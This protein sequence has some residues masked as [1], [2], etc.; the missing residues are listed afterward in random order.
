MSG[1]RIPNANPFQEGNI[2]SSLFFTAQSE[3]RAD[4]LVEALP[5][6][7][8]G[9]ELEG[10]SNEELRSVV[11]SQDEQE[12]YEDTRYVVIDDQMA[13]GKFG[14]IAT[15]T[16]FNEEPYYT[17]EEFTVE[18]NSTVNLP[19]L[20]P[21]YDNTTL[22]RLYYDDADSMDGYRLVH[23]TETYTLIG[24]LADLS[25]PDSRPQ[26]NSRFTRAH[27]NDSEAVGFRLSQVGNLPDGQMIRAGG[28]SYL[29]DVRGTASVKTFERVEGATITGEAN[30]SEPRNVTAFVRMRT[31]NTER[32][33]PYTKR[34]ETDADGSFEMTVPY[35]TI[36]DV[37]VEE[38]GTNA[39]VESAG[40]Y[41]VYVGNV[42]VASVLGTSQVL[43]NPVESGTVNI[44]ESTVYEGDEVDVS[45]EEVETGNETT[46]ETV[47]NETTGNATD[48]TD[49]EGDSTGAG[50]A[51][52]NE[53][54]GT[55]GA[56]T[57]NGS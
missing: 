24:N 36:D 15:W 50:N 23:E 6:V 32:T 46:N 29:Y 30:V 3:E 2:V 40:P 52:A 55:T 31:T 25:Q 54:S 56:E 34:V 43:G 33:F 20:G 10:M 41:Q 17:R 57:Q 48:A 16:D 12:R 7:D 14:A 19:A 1:E 38:G 4:L 26:L 37:P 18:Q 22:S 39:S 35:P 47:G 53:T 8:S 42:G 44:T 45:L 11:E 28:G 5:S 49:G 27:Y 9:S 51:T 13:A 21:R